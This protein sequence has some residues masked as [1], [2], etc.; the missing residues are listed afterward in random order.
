[1]SPADVGF[2]DTDRRRAAGLRR[3]EVCSI[4]GVAVSWLARLEQGRAHSVSPDVL[5]ALAQAL[6]LDETERAHLFALAGL[7]ADRR[8]LPH[9]QISPAL[10]VL[11]HE[12]EPNPAYLLDR[13]W[14]IIAWNEAEAALFP[15]L[16]DAADAT[17]NL[18]EL[19]FGNADL[20]RLMVDHNEEFVRLVSQLRLHRTDWPDDPELGDLIAR[21]EATSAD[22]ARLWAAKDVAP[23]AA[24][25]RVF[26]H[27]LAGHLEFDHHRFSAL[28]QAGTQLVVYTSRPGSDS[29]IQLREA[30]AGWEN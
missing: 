18:L 30:T 6:R 2:P 13:V 19:V 16:L 11:L 25:R 26:A 22:F 10:R 14:N 21:L 20:Q 4:A 5:E 3:E 7:R 1:V 24:T 12:L 17:P 28:D 27:P 9:P 15:G 8:D 23:F 29:A